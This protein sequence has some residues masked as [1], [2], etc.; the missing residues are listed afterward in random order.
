[1]P[2][3]ST[4]D[5]SK[6][7]VT[8]LAIPCYSNVCTLRFVF[9]TPPEENNIPSLKQKP[10]AEEASNQSLIKSNSLKD[11][12]GALD[13]QTQRKHL[14]YCCGNHYCR[15]ASQACSQHSAATY[16]CWY[17]AGLFLCRWLKANAFW[18]ISEQELIEA[19]ITTTVNQS[20]SPKHAKIIEAVF[21]TWYICVG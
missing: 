11:S 14:C 9:R 15:H 1:M 2:L 7:R 19:F 20:L 17:V 12:D 16:F 10:N 6:H 4:P 3:S 8:V 5:V 18:A 21:G 13:R